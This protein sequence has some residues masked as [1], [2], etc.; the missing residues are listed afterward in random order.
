VLVPQA[1]SAEQA[2][3]AQSA[4]VGQPIWVCT[5]VWSMSRCVND[6][7]PSC[8]CNAN[9]L[10]LNTQTAQKCC[11]LGLEGEHSTGCEC[12]VIGKCQ[13]CTNDCA[14]ELQPAGHPWS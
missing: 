4:R 11:Q 3:C 7:R 10:Q 14:V 5:C 6:R 9:G 12:A 2:W 8:L 1:V 13:L